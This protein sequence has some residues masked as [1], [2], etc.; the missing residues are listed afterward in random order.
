MMTGHQNLAFKSYLNQMLISDKQL[1]NRFPLPINY[2]KTKMFCIQKS[3]MHDL[4][5]FLV[6]FSQI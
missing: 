2:P 5:L 4:H 3:S 1:I 6:K